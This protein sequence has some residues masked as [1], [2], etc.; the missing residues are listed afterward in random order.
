MLHSPAFVLTLMIC[1]GISIGTARAEIRPEKVF[2]AGLTKTDAYVRDGLI[3]GGDRAVSEVV[4]K[5]IRRA[6]NSGYER[7]VIDLEGNRNGE[8]V[9]IERAPYFQ[10]SITP[11]E[12]RLVV[13]LFGKPKLGFDPQKVL[14]AFKKSAVIERIVLLPALDEGSWTFSLELKSGRPVEVFELASPVRLIMDIRSH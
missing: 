5:D 4:I 13:T 12:K 7:I 3:T 8:P 1:A 11:D 6:S 14:A 9:A 10:V 2:S